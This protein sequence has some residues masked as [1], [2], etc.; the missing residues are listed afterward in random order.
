MK[1]QFFIINVSGYVVITLDF[2]FIKYFKGGHGT[3]FKTG[4]FWHLKWSKASSRFFCV[5]ECSNL[6]FIYFSY[7]YSWKKVAATIFCFI[8]I[9]FQSFLFDFF[10]SYY[11]LNRVSITSQLALIFCSNF[12]PM[13]PAVLIIM[14]VSL[15]HDNV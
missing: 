12:W 4:I 5:S 3:K 11:L 6:R 14:L 8:N 15:K 1:M 9:N 13:F 2:T 10:I 7:K